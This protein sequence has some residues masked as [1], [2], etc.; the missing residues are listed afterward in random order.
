MR[1]DYF[2]LD[3]KNRLFHCCVEKL[4]KPNQPLIKTTLIFS[5]LTSVGRNREKKKKNFCIFYVKPP[6]GNNCIFEFWPQHD[7]LMISFAND[8]SIKLGL[9]KFTTR[10]FN[11]L[12]QKK[13]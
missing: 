13:D 12:C 5:S 3:S 8:S 7:R 2:F 4:L 1:V 6:R 9:T 11:S 10:S